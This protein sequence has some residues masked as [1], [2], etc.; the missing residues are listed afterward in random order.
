MDHAVGSAREHDI[1]FALTDDFTGF[2]DGL[3]AGSAGGEAIQ[4][5]SLGIEQAGEMASRHVRLLLHFFLGIEEFQAVLCELLHI[6]LA[7]LLGQGDHPHEEVEIL[8]TFPRSEVNPKASRV[9]GVLN[10]RL[11]DRLDGSADGVTDV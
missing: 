10:A 4:V 2:A 5:R 11:L 9:N 8:L 1:S 3:A 6:E 7:A